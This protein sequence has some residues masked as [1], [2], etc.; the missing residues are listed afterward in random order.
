MGN[1]CL[2]INFL[3]SVMSYILKL[4]FLIKSFFCMTT[5]LGQK[6]KYLKYKKSLSGEIKLFLVLKEFQSQEVASDLWVG[7]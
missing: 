5:K 1:R 3:Q 6:F 2:V 4:T 7:V